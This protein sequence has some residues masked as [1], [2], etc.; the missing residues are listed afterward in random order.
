MA[1]VGFSPAEGFFDEIPML[2]CVCLSHMTNDEA[3]A[4]A[5]ERVLRVP[6]TAPCSKPEGT[7]ELSEADSARFETLLQEHEEALA[8]QRGK[9]DASALIRTITPLLAAVMK[10]ERRGRVVDLSRDNLKSGLGMDEIFED[11]SD[12]AQVT[13]VPAALRTIAGVLEVL[14]VESSYLAEVP[15]WVGEMTRLSTLAVGSRFDLSDFD[16]PDVSD[17]YMVGNEVTSRV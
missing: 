1:K 14:K 6:C 11:D 5:V 12:R 7:G 16:A 3:Q 10:A 15:P 2:V 9:P 13:E 8:A 17:F 4:R